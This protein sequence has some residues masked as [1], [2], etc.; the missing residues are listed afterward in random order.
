MRG[1]LSRGWLMG[2]TW[3]V[4]GCIPI[5]FEGGSFYVLIVTSGE[6]S[7]SLWTLND[8]AQGLGEEGDCYA[9]N[10]AP[11]PPGIL[12]PVRSDPA[13]SRDDLLQEYVKHVWKPAFS[14]APTFLEWYSAWLDRCQ[15]DLEE[16]KYHPVPGPVIQIKGLDR[17]TRIILLVM[18]IIMVIIIVLIEGN[19]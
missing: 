4:G 5:C 6:L 13:M 9:Y 17:T 16:R 18:L 15:A 2:R 3:P 12:Q 11:P 14:P 7:G 8:T 1:E 19:K 10:L